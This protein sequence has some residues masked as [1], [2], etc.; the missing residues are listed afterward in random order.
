M[1]TTITEPS[2]GWLPALLQLA[3]AAFPTGSYAHSFGLEEIVRQGEVKDEATLGAFLRERF[4]PALAHVDLPLVREARSAAA[5]RDR[6][7][8]MA[9]DRLAGALRLSRELRE[10]SLQTGRRRLAILIRLRPTP[11]LELLDQICR[12]DPL[13]GHHAIVWGA[14]CASVPARAALEAY[15]YHSVSCLCTAAPK[16]IRLGQ[17]GV[18]RVL[19]ECLREADHRVTKAFGV[20]REAIGWFDPTLDIASMHHEVAD[21]RL[22]IS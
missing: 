20:S 19:S 4:I 2:G 18:Q 6:A 22:F 1:P 8:L 21:E 16:L 9:L 12:E 13:A 11:E 7:D 10:A 5:A 3:D 15:Y 17:E 14:S